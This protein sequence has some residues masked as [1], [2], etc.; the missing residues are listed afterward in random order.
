MSLLRLGGN[1]MVL[2]GCECVLIGIDCLI[3]QGML[4]FIMCDFRDMINLS[5]L[6]NAIEN[7]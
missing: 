2:M 4:F 6:I 1:F 3:G 5:N 7:E